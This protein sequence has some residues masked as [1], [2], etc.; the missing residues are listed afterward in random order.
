MKRLPFKHVA[1][2]LQNIFL[3]FCESV[4]FSVIEPYGPSNKAGNIWPG[5]LWSS[6]E[7]GWRFFA[8]SSNPLFYRLTWPQ[9]TRTCSTRPLIRGDTS[10]KLPSHEKI[11]A[12][13]WSE[14][15]LNVSTFPPSVC[16][17]YL[18]K[19][20]LHLELRLRVLVHEI[21]TVQLL[22]ILVEI[23]K[24]ESML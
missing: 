3:L 15:E 8:S 19:E 20:G 24:L 11:S 1:V 10:Y 12:S 7:R 14:T 22:Y 5:A 6:R 17:A 9:S 18:F 16:M 23:K 2:F 21:V 4:N 13:I